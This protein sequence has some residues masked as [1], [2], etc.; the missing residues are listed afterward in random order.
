MAKKRVKYKNRNKTQRQQT[1]N[2]NMYGR[3][4]SNISTA[5]LNMILI[6]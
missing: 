4:E 5:N 2:S 6:H 3:Y 1:E